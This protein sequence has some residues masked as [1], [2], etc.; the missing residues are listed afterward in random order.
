MC[1]TFMLSLDLILKLLRMNSI[2][3]NKRKDLKLANS[4][5]NPKVPS[6]SLLLLYRVDRF[7]IRHNILSAH[8]LIQINS[9]HSLASNL[10]IP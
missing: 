2:K 3:N 4:E 10:I 1:L 7:Y 6:N 9:S 8:S 5:Q